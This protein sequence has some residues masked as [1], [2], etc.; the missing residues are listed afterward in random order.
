MVRPLDIRRVELLA[1]LL[2]FLN[3]G[4]TTGVP[5]CNVDGYVSGTV[6]VKLPLKYAAVFPG[7]YFEFECPIPEEMTGSY[8]RLRRRYRMITTRKKQPTRISNVLKIVRR[9]RIQAENIKDVKSVVIF[10]SK[11]NVSFQCDKN[12]HFEPRYAKNIYLK[13]QDYY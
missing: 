6:S 2:V 8:F 10:F 3:G 12:I 5:D 1:V 11:L 9:T 4:N 7:A 13:I